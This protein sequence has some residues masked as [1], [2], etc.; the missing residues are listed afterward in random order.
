MWTKILIF[1]VV[2]FLVANPATF[3]IVRKVL[4]SWVASA[5]GLATPAGLVLHA[6]VFVALAIFLPKALM[7]ASGY[8]AEAE[9]YAE[10]E[11]EDY[12]EDE[13]EDYEGEDEFA[14][15][16]AEADLAAAEQRIAT[17]KARMA[18]DRAAKAGAAASTMAAPAVVAPGAAPITTVSKYAEDE[19]VGYSSMY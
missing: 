9:D 2:F 11:K 8:E 10:D 16:Q 4:G 19:F 14:D 13:K 6:A 12:A 3:K 18:A 17:D 15:L 5:D 1:M 7:R